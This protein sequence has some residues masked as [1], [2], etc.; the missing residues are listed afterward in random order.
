MMAPFLACAADIVGLLRRT[1]FG[2]G[3][4]RIWRGRDGTSPESKASV[5]PGRAL[6]ENEERAGNDGRG[7]VASLGGG[8]HWVVPRSAW[9]KLDVSSLSA[10]KEK[11]EI[12]ITVIFKG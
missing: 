8:G 2:G 5:P 10:E 1:F 9:A 3:L 4:V 6:T 12:L 11:K 7:M